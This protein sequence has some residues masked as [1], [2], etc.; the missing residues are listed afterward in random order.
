M[1]TQDDVNE[2]QPQGKLNPTGVT[3]DSGYGSAIAL[4]GDGNYA[5]VGDSKDNA[6]WVF[7]RTKDA[8]GVPAWA[9]QG[10]PIGTTGAS[11]NSGFGAS[12]AIS[13]DSYTMIVGGPTDANNVG[14]A[15]VFTRQGGTWTQVQKLTGT[16]AGSGF[17]T[18]VALSYEG[19]MA[20]VGGRG[21][22]QGVGAAWLFRLKS[23]GTWTQ[24]GYA[25]PT[26]KGA[27]WFGQDVALSADGSIALVGSYG[28]STAYLLTYD[29]DPETGETWSMTQVPNTGNIY[30][31]GRSV[32]ISADGDILLIGS[33]NGT[34][35]RIDN[36]RSPPV[37]TLQN[38]PNRTNF[39]N[40]VALSA[41][42]ATAVIGDWDTGTGAVG[43]VYSFSDAGVW[44]QRQRLT[45]T[46]GGLTG[47]SA[48][49][50]VCLSSDGH[51]A[52]LADFGLL[53]PTA[54]AWIFDN[55]NAASPITHV[56]VLM[57]ENHSFDV[58]F[59]LSGI[60]GITTD[61]PG[62]SNSYNGIGYPVASPAPPS[63]PTDPGHEF[64]DVLEQLC[65]AGATLTSAGGY[66]P[67]KID[68]SGFVSNYA[69]TTTESEGGK[70]PLPTAAQYGDI[71]KCFDTK[72]QLPVLYQLATE[73]ALCDHW[74]S[75]LPGPTF[76][77][78]FFLHGGSSSG[79]ADSP[80]PTTIAKWE[81]VEGFNY[82]N[83]SIYDAL[84]NI[85][86]SYRIYTDMTGPPVG[87]VPQVAAIKG[88]KFE[89]NTSRYSDFDSAVK[90][91]TYPGG[92]TFI[93]PSYGDSL[94]G[95][96]TGGS[97]QHPMDG[98]Y[99]GE[100]LIKKTYESIRSSPHWNTSLLI[101]TYDEHGG[102]YDS[103]AP[104]AATAP[105]DTEL[106]KA[107]TTFDFQTFGVRVPGVIVSPLIPANTI[108]Q[109]VYDH[110]SVLTTLGQVFG[111]GPLTERVKAANGL[112]QLASLSAPRTDCPET[113]NAPAPPPQMP[114]SEEVAAAA[115]DGAISD[116]PSNLHGFLAVARKIDMEMAVG[117]PARRVQIEAEFQAIQTTGQ[118]R[119]YIDAVM[120]RATAARDARSQRTT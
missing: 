32:A 92:Y 57:L 30:E 77:N 62:N 7:T 58:M 74:F 101:I 42:G 94:S 36:S 72:T 17:G 56:F 78:R 61:A 45:G 49:M 86:V 60:P 80:D 6:V 15:W 10:P 34:A 99:Q 23:D 40:S 52:F 69:T 2:F 51:T 55:H 43:W 88:I 5:V 110:T 104:G 9:Q 47:N 4:S 100:L 68:M 65:G 73:F 19:A 48:G 111:V 76:P 21:G 81:T 64:A 85:G 33:Y 41:D 53:R 27:D 96:F 109:T 3:V 87:W 11:G 82:A 115:M 26:E 50:S 112:S 8:A 117:D 91:P 79:L 95:T 93:E 39:S 90:D 103:I 16:G 97:S 20:V 28:K 89:I 14:A 113:L 18:S 1:A 12:I 71:M 59:G 70:L 118:A 25:T 29:D 24:C 98:L 67:G 54:Q 108:S 102:F 84:R 116:S 35:T 22:Y 114:R 106:H 13:Q 107:A 44:T 105:G 120:T 31:F 83:G 119:D 63:M 75:S 66:P 46:E 37:V 38:I